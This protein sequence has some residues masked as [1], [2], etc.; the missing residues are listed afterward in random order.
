MGLQ[1]FERPEIR[2]LKGEEA[3]R[4]LAEY[5]EELETSKPEELTEE[6]T[7][8]MI[9]LAKG[10]VSAIENEKTTPPIF[11][12]SKLVPKLRRT[13]GG[14][15]SQIFQDQANTVLTQSPEPVRPDPYRPS[16]NQ[17]MI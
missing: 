9:K 3:K 17:Q 11:E 6:Q 15:L 1:D 7:K 13:V 14:F 4:V 16:P 2:V 5:I 12:R 10:L 8:T